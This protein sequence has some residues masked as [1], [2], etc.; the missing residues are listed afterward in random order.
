MNNFHPPMPGDKAMFY[1]MNCKKSFSATVPGNGIA[2]IF[3]K[4]ANHGQVKCPDCKKPCGLDPKIQ[5]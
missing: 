2:G 3:N 4:L 1:C 5:S